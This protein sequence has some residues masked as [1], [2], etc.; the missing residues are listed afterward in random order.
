MIFE[1]C[2]QLSLGTTVFLANNADPVYD[3]IEILLK[4]LKIRNGQHWVQDTKRRQTYKK[5]SKKD[6]TEKLRD[7]QHRPHQKLGSELI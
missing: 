7:K 5:P 2:R 4:C 6:I 3:M 1:Y